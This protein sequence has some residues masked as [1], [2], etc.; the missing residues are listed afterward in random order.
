MLPK[1][2]IIILNWNGKDDTVECLESLKKIDYQNYDIILVDNGSTDGSQE[3]IKKNYPYVKLIENYKNL[4]FAEGCNIGIKASTSGYLLLLNNDMIFDRNMIN[5]LL[6][7]MES[8][9]KIGLVSPKMYFYDKKNVIWSVGGILRKYSTWTRGYNEIDSGQYDTVADIDFW[10]G[11]CLIKRKV[12]DE[13]GLFDPEFFVYLEDV[14][15]C[16]RIKKAGYRVVYAPKAVLW[17]KCHATSKRI[18][19][20]A[21]FHGEKNMLL[22]AMMHNF[23]TPQFILLNILHS[24]KLFVECMTS[25]RF[26]EAKAILKAKIWFLNR[27]IKPKSRKNE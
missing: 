10:S 26:K 11:C 19:D 5:E 4:G 3:I 25:G 14:D 15:L 21:R 13:V 18:S 12:L 22:L 7:V 2:S 20:I 8:D 6:V 1:V 24:I 16:L 17:H 27:L 23:L 9:K